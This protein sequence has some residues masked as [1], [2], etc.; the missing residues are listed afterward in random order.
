MRTLAGDADTSDVMRLVRPPTFVLATQGI[1]DLLTM[2]RRQGSHLAIVVDEFG[3]VAGLAT[4]EDLLEEL[5]GEIRDEYDQEEEPPFLQ[6]EDGSWLVDGLQ[7]Y[8]KVQERLG[9]SADAATPN[10][11]F[12]TL[13]GLIMASLN[14]I[15]QVGDSVTLGEYTL[16]VVDMDGRRIDK[17]LV[18]KTLREDYEASP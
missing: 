6:R 2:F 13:A 3:Q 10:A 16:E 17:V 1:D 9:L 11:D 5:V 18:R 7:A 12:T 15:P 4:L 14:R 8:D